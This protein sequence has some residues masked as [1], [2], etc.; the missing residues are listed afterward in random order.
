MGDKIALQGILAQTLTDLKRNRPELFTLT[1][2]EQIANL[3]GIFLKT[4]LT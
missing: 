2:E 1:G 4:I 3:V